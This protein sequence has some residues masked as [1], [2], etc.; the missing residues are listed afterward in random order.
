[1]KWTPKDVIAVIIVVGCLILLTMG[2]N[3][4]ISWA[5]LAVVGAYYGLDL[6]PWVKLGRNQKS[7]KEDE[8]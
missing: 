8:E 6:T 2:R 1:M 7:K 3:S 5:L 4:V